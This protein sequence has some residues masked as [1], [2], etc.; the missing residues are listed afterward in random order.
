M[1]ST[2]AELAALGNDQQF[3]LRVRSIVIQVAETVLQEPPA[4]PDTRRNFARQMLAAPDAA[5]RLAVPVANTTNLKAGATTYD[6]EAGNV[7][8]DVTD[9]ALYAQITA[10]WDLL[11]GV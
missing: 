10:A 2:A 3:Q 9:D 5:Q 6:F 1:A 7:V 11:A 4:N 8:T